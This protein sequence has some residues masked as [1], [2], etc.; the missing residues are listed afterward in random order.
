MVQ[1][2]NRSMAGVTGV[3]NVGCSAKKSIVNFC[4]QLHTILQHP[5]LKVS[6]LVELPSHETAYSMFDE[7]S[8]PGGWWPLNAFIELS[9]GIKMDETSRRKSCEQPC[10]C[11]EDF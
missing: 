2:F 8:C 10:I 11:A 1:P 5:F 3:Q 6:A 9:D 4:E 7:G